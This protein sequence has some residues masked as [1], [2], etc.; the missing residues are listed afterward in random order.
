MGGTGHEGLEIYVTMGFLIGAVTKTSPLRNF[1]LQ[2][3]PEDALSAFDV[4]HQMGVA[5]GKVTHLSLYQVAANPDLGECSDDT[6]A[7]LFAA[8]ETDRPALGMNLEGI[9]L[10]IVG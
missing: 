7:R 6:F 2:F 1:E 5:N 9:A 10:G 8:P 4:G 3:F